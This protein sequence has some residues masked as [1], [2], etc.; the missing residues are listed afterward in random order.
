MK[1]DK[2]SRLEQI[3]GELKPDTKKKEICEVRGLPPGQFLDE[4][5]YLCEIRH[6]IPREVDV[7]E[8]KQCI[9]TLSSW[10][11]GEPL[12]FSI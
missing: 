3:L 2:H 4:D 6:E 7:N 1:G 12:V 5:I 8:H 11:A 10:G 9:K